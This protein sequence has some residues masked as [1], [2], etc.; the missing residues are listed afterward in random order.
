[1]LGFQWLCSEHIHWSQIRPLVLLL[2]VPITYFSF[3]PRRNMLSP[4]G[5]E[6]CLTS[7]DH[8]SMLSFRPEVFL[9][10]WSTGSRVEPRWS[11]PTT[12]GSSMTAPSSGSPTS[13]SRTSGPTPA[14][15]RIRKGTWPS[16]PSW[17]K[18]VTK[19]R[20]WFFGHL[21]FHLTRNMTKQIEGLT[22]GLG[23]VCLILAVLGYYF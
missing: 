15:P 1:M 17:S 3:V 7:V 19:I 21:G 23:V 14:W 16:T 5:L 22:L 13:S 18:Q 11:R 10:P 4:K 9:S 6:N 2:K 8:L 20:R 12:S